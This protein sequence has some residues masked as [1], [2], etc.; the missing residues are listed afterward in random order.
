MR[1]LALFLKIAGGFVI[2]AL[3]GVVVLF[4]WLHLNEYK[5]AALEEV[6]VT[7]NAV[8]VV[9]TGQH[10]ELYTWNIGYAALDSGADFFM[11]G[12]KG[13]RPASRS[14]VEKNIWAIQ[15]FLAGSGADFVFLQEVDRNSRRSWEIDEAGYFAGTWKGSA[16]YALNYK[17]PFIPYPVPRFTG[18][19]ESGL[20][21][22]SVFNTYPQAERVALPEAFDWPLR[23]GQLKRC[24]LVER[25][26]VRNS[27]AE[28]VLVNFHLEAYDSGEGREEQ[29]RVL[30]EFLKTEYARGNY[31]V[32]G[33]DFNQNLPGA[34]EN[35][36]L[37]NADAGFIP[38][39][40]PFPLPEGF[41]LASDPVVPSARLL[42]KPYTER[43][44]HQ[45]YVI[46]GFLVSPNVAVE[47]V[48]TLDLDFRNSDHNPVKLT[49]SLR[50]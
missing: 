7:R 42:D 4:V 10:L 11:E 5:P 8:P 37:K 40:F 45:F 48:Q 23:L 31:C 49:F 2:L 25:L 14:L 44:D 26:P 47:S 22:L 9:S 29:T 24:L 35:F 20:L 1:L 38:G 12:G 43:E 21:T 30:L 34:E 27:A 41:T 6:S 18:R 50:P 32:S 15:S 46:D 13:V 39:V 19:V 3:L 36:P 28:L 16:A 17:C 33:G